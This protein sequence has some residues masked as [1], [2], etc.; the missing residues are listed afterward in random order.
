MESTFQVTFV[1]TNL[2]LFSKDTTLWFAL[3]PDCLI[4]KLGCA[5]Y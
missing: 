2:T 5:I 1:I 3:E 4:L